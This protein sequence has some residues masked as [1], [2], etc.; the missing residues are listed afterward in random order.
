MSQSIVPL[1]V[2]GRPTKK[3]KKVVAKLLEIFKIGGNVDEAASYAGIDRATYY[4]W[5]KADP[6]FATEMEQ[7][8]HFSD[9]VAKN[10][11]VQNITEKRSLDASKWWLEKRQFKDAGIQVSGEK[12]LVIPGELL[13][14]YA[15]KHTEE[16]A[17]VLEA[18]VQSEDV[19]DKDV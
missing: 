19:S 4:R 6:A 9:V 8:R 10:V 14:K 18:E 11:V 12:V 17:K 16:D 7:A 13:D 3:T 2:G 5:L 1:D 15:I